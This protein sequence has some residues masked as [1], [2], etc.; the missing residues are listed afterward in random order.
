MTRVME[1]RSNNNSNHQALKTTFCAELVP[2]SFSIN[3][4][5]PMAAAKSSIY[6]PAALVSN[7]GSRY[8]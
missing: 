8:L 6:N 4:A 3:V 2:K 1:K 5:I 7:K